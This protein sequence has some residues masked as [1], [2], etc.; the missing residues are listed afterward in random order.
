MKAREVM[1]LLNICRTTLY[2][3]TKNNIIKHTKLSNGYYDYDEHSVLKFI[4]KDNRYDV[5]YARVSTYKQKNDLT[6]Q[7][8]KLQ[9][10]CDN[11]KINIQHVYSEIASGIDLDRTELSK[12]LDD[13][14]T[15][16]IKNIFISN[17][18]RLTR[19]SFKTLESLL[20]RFNTNIIV[21]NDLNNQTNDNEIF[22]ELISLMHIFST[23]MYSNRRKNKI[24]I[25]KQDIENFISD[26]TTIN[27]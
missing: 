10:Y 19:L 4:K 16:K 14:F 8:N 7:T 20:K 21:I 27:N 9:T 22:E 2:H 24:N 13:I 26:D 25:Y 6:N 15:H 23:T 17:K 18:D 1:K 3:Y 11:N 5:I 12:L